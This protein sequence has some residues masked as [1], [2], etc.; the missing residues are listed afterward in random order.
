MRV[1]RIEPVAGLKHSFDVVFDNNEKLRCFTKNIADFGLKPNRELSEER[2]EELKDAIAPS[3][4]RQRAARLI[5]ARQ[6]SAG[7]LSG[8]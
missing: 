6:M 1:E 8:G 4:T 2:F 3:R 7:E 5:S